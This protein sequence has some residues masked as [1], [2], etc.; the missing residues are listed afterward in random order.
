MTTREHTKLDLMVFAI[1]NDFFGYGSKCYKRK[2]GRYVSIVDC[3]RA[4]YSGKALA[5]EWD[6]LDSQERTD[7]I[8]EFAKNE[9]LQQPEGIY[10][11]QVP[12]VWYSVEPEDVDYLGTDDE[13]EVAKEIE[14]IKGSLPQFFSFTIETDDEDELEQMIADKITEET[15]WFV[16]SFEYKII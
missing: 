14:R 6:T 15:G 7:I 2:D 8:E 11:I 3:E 4:V 9:L 16:E 13:E 1:N 12:R 10:H 5:D